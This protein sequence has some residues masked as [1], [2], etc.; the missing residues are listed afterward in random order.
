MFL[1]EGVFI[2]LFCQLVD[3]LHFTSNG[4]SRAK[5]MLQAKFG[6]ADVVANLY[7]NCIISLPVVFGSQANKVLDFHE[8]LMSNVKALETMR[9]LNE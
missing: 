4:Y 1:S 3:S 8:K 7:S 6:K 5:A 2:I 9:K